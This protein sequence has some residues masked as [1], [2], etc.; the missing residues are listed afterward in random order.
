[1]V[2]VYEVVHVKQEMER[3]IGGMSVS[4]S[5]KSGTGLCPSITLRR[6]TRKKSVS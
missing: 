2:I 1:M 3:K 5:Q 6:L 4:L